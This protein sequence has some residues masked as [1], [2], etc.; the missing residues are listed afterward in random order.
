MKRP[1]NRTDLPVYSISSKCNDEFNMNICTYV[2]GAS[3]EPKRMSVAI[4]K[5]TKTLALAE[6][7]KQFVLQ[8]LAK[9][10]LNLVKY[11]GFKSGFNTDKNAYLRKK[12]LIKTWNGFEVLKDALA[13]IHLKQIK[14]IDAGDHQLFLCDVVGF[15][16][17]LDADGLTLNEL[18]RKK[19]IRG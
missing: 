5:E 2:A 4:Y 11:L 3:M 7:E 15:L 12:D 17:N 13:Y 1:W 16:N 18:R 10:Q 9:D 6:R 8:L 14:S 19:I